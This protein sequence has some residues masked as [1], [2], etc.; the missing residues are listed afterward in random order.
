M[1]GW[2]GA[3]RRGERGEGI[4]GIERGGAEREERRGAG[5]VGMG[6]RWGWGGFV[7]YCHMDVSDV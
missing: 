1:G 7:D 5:F 4:E 3:G 6:W 2:D